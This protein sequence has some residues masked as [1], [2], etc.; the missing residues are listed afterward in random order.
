MSAQVTAVGTDM[1]GTARSGVTHGVP[2]RCRL[3]VVEAQGIPS[4]TP[5]PAPHG[6][7]K[8]LHYP[9]SFWWISPWPP[10][11]MKFLAASR[12]RPPSPVS[13]GVLAQFSHLPPGP[14][15]CFQD[16]SPG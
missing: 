13:P 14:W 5:V 16:P 7:A 10:P 9:W 3:H 4:G 1:E 2:P 6:R 12:P 15:L 11:A 8:G